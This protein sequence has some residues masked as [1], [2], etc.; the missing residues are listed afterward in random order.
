[1]T[2]V[3]KFRANDLTNKGRIVIDDARSVKESRR[4]WYY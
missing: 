1:M 3:F 2:P 4:S